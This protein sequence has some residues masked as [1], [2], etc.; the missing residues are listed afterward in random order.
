MLKTIEVNFMLDYLFG[1]CRIIE[2]MP[3]VYFSGLTETEV[4]QLNHAT[5]KEV[6][7]CWQQIHRS[8]EKTSQDLCF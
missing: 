4:D 7:I 8:I 6:E 3:M 2:Q 5:P 1:L